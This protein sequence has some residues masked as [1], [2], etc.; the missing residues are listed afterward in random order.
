[1]PEESRTQLPVRLDDLIDAVKRGYDNPLDQ[2]S[3]AVVA[4]ESLGDISDHLIGHFVDQARRTGA[5]WS[6]IGQ[7]MGVSKQAAQKRFVARPATD[8]APT[9]NPAAGFSQYSAHARQVVVGAQELARTAGHDQIRPAHLVIGLLDRSDATASQ[10]LAAQVD[11]EALRSA[12]VV[13][14]PDPVAVVPALIPFDDD[15]RRAL[16]ATFA[17]AQGL[18][19]TQIGTE[20]VLLALLDNAA[21]ADA[22]A[23]AGADPAAV[24]EQ[25]RASAAG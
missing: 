10:A 15:A 12:L 21:V 25:L 6:Q 3:S 2:L 9:L 8:A 7:S 19:A 11:L 4:A 22:L 14:L 16:E 20:H 23:A 17:H 5:S 1:M 24:D 13:T 18:G